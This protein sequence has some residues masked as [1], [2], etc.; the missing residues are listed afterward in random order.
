MSNTSLIEYMENHSIDPHT[1]TPVLRAETGL[2]D[3]YDGSEEYL[4]VYLY[5]GY[6]KEYTISYQTYVGQKEK[7]EADVLTKAWRE[8]QKRSWYEFLLTHATSQVDS[9]ASQI[10]KAKDRVGLLEESLATLRQF[11]GGIR[12]ALLELHTG[13]TDTEKVRELDSLVDDMYRS[14]SGMK[15]LRADIIGKP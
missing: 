5:W 14:I 15:K 4:K 10:E 9:T 3:Q 8:D 6:P 2:I 1:S 12:D 11:H 7:I 13:G